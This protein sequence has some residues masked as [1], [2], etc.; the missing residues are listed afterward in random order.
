MKLPFSFF[1]LRQ[2]GDL[3]M[4]LNSNTTIRETLTSTAL[5]VILDSILVLSYLVILLYIHFFLGCVVIILGGLRILIYALT[6]RRHRE[7]M[8][9]SLQ[10]MAESSNY[11]VQMLSGIETIKTAGAERRV[12]EHW[13]N[14]LADVLNVSIERGKLSAIVGATFGAIGML[15]PLVLLGYGAHLVIRGDLSLGTMLALNALAAG[16]LGP[17]TS[18][19][20]TALSLKML[21]SYIERVEDVLEK[22]PEQDDTPR[23]LAPKLS[24]RI[25]LKNVSF[26]YSDHAPLVVDDASLLIEA[27]MTVAIVGRSGSGK[28]TLTR[29]LVGLVKPESGEILYDDSSFEIYDLQSF[30]SQFG[31]IPQNPF[32]FATTV[33]NNI[34]VN[35]PKTGF[36]EIQNAARMACIHE[37]VMQMPLQYDTTVAAAGASLSGGQQQ[38]IALARAIVGNPAILVLDE[39]TS[40]LDAITEEDVHK[41]LRKLNCTRIVIA[42]RLSVIADADLILVMD[43]GRIVERGAHDELMSKKG[44]YAKLVHSQM[45]RTHHPNVDT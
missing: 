7:L 35:D 24:G 31:F 11:Q 15:S 41:N 16:F 34:A 9:K 2:T 39:A 40:H 27:G 17:L 6:Q 8:S 33:R 1:L 42:Q 18:L 32:V 13:A 5:T 3:M 19:V 45:R 23:Q 28:S 44:E 29:L 38:R 36:E 30:R 25:E 10:T 21:G 12:I 37:D 26:R 20:S 43:N 22:A 14:L 4:R